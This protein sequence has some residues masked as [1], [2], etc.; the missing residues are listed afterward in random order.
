MY[1]LSETNYVINQIEKNIQ[2]TYPSQ[3]TNSDQKKEM[4]K[5]QF[6]FQKT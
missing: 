1:I 3:E 4:I 6:P 5:F 2:R